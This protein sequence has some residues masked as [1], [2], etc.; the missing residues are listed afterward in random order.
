V[1]AVVQLGFAII[2]SCFLA[3][4]A[5]ISGMTR[6]TFESI[7]KAELLSIATTPAAAAAGQS[8]FDK[9]P[10]AENIA[11]SSPSKHDSVASSIMTDS[12]NAETRLPAERLDAKS[13][14]SSSGSF[15]FSKRKISSWA[16][17]TGRAH[18]TY[19]VTHCT[20]FI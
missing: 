3:A 5:L 15:L 7:L 20:K 18:N 1:I 8:T 17:R 13:L 14:N 9:V 16:D 11:K 2:P 10:L 12:P 19:F 4:A 6:G